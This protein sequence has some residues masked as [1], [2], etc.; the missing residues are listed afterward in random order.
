MAYI[1]S[2]GEKKE[3]PPIHIQFF[4]F[5]LG[6]IRF[7]EEFFLS[8]FMPEKIQNMNGDSSSGKGGGDGGGTGPKKVHGLV[9]R[10]E[11]NHKTCSTCG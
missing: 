2:T 4:R 9:N 3:S 1:S 5:I 11:V 8:I 7:I 6:I 10:K